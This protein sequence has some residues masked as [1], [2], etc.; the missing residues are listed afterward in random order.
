MRAVWVLHLA[1]ILVTRVLACVGLDDAPC[2]CNLASKAGE[3]MHQQPGR[4]A[5]ITVDGFELS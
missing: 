4:H 2:V 5:E 1:P 3:F